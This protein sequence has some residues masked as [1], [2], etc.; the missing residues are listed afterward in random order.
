MKD[1]H[2]LGS[3]WKLSTNCLVYLQPREFAK[4]RLDGQS[5]DARATTGA[6]PWNRCSDQFVPDLAL[7]RAS[8]AQELRAHGRDRHAHFSET[9]DLALVKAMINHAAW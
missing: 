3:R 1:V 4:W 6:G 8:W 2:A 9:P 7:K 5:R